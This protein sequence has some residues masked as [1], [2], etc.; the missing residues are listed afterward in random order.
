MLIKEFSGK[1]DAVRRFREAGCQGDARVSKA[2][3]VG[4]RINLTSARETETFM[5][6][7]REVERLLAEFPTVAGLWQLFERD[8]QTPPPGNQ[9][10]S[11]L[12]VVPLQGP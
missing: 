3:G 9:L 7:G 12:P 11:D 5:L 1:L 4:Y 8:P 6:K 10:S 2:L